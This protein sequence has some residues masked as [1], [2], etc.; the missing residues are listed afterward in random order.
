[1]GVWEWAPC[2][3]Q[4]MQPEGEQRWSHCDLSIIPSGKVSSFH[5]WTQALIRHSKEG[6]KS[7]LTCGARQA[8]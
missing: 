7:I 8:A 4:G 3:G 5:I 6:L 2:P 1:M